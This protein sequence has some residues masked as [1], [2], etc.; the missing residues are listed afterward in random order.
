M[1]RKKAPRSRADLQVLQAAQGVEHTID[2]AMWDLEQCDSKKCSGRKLERLGMIRSISIQQ[3]FRGLV[4]SPVGKI[5][6]SREDKEI[7]EEFGTA[8]IDCSWAL[9]DTIQ[10]S[11]MKTNYPRLLPYL[12]AANPINYGKPW[13][14]SCVEALAATLWITGWPDLAML[15]LDK[16]KWGHGFLTL[17]AELLDAY[18]ACDTAAEVEEIHNRASAGESITDETSESEEEVDVEEHQESSSDDG[19]YSNFTG[20]NL[21]AVDINDLY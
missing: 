14:L 12:V 11:K 10:F 19:D 16:F 6:V 1:A 4:L 8:V 18:A 5:Y 20:R 15:L 17:N 3:R 21:D 9:V 2:L 7:V 13:K